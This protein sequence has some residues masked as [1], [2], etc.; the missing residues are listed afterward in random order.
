MELN[1]THSEH[2]HASTRLKIVLLV[3]AIVVVG[4]LGYLVWNQNTSTDTTDN[5]LVIKNKTIAVDPT[6]NWKTYP[7][8]GLKF[9]FKYP[10]TFTVADNLQLTGKGTAASQNLTLTDSTSAGHPTLE[11]LV[12][13]AGFDGSPT[14]LVYTFKL[15][16]DYTLST[17]TTVK[18][19][20]DASVLGDAT[21]YIAGTNIAGQLLSGRT[22]VI[23]YS[24]LA[25]SDSALST[26]DQ[27]IKTF[28][29]NP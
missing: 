3:F 28:K 4:A 17:V 21:H 16:S 25:G 18:Q 1:E 5:G 7:N 6:A 24:Y 10:A 14:N 13:P 2:E 19:A 22:F 23:R 12:D 11:V 20:V 9:S 27:L 26:F 15:N 8:T 29:I